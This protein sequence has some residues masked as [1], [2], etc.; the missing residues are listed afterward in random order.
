MQTRAKLKRSLNK[1]GTAMELD[2]VRKV[3]IMLVIIVMTIVG[4]LAAAV[5]LSSSSVNPGN[6]VVGLTCINQ[7]INFTS[8]TSAV[9]LACT[10]NVTLINFDNITVING[11]GGEVLSNGNYT[12]SGGGIAAA[13]ASKYNGSFLQVSGVFRA[14]DRGPEAIT[15]N[16]TIG[17]VGFFQSMPTIMAV[18]GAMVIISIIILIFFAVSRFGINARAAGEGAAGGI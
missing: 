12:I 8:T 2:T 16:S 14:Y 13:A 9:P 17:I 15:R 1:K 5:T 7:S 4:L 11:S 6:L 18:L 10:A 3:I